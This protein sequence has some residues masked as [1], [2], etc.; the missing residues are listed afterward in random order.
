MLVNPTLVFAESGSRVRPPQLDLRGLLRIGLGL[1][2]MVLSHFARAER[3]LDP[4]LAP[5]VDVWQ[6]KSLH[7]YGVMIRAYVL[8]VGGLYAAHSGLASMQIGIMHWMGYT[9]PERYRLPFL[10]TGPDDFWRRWNRWVGAWA[11]RYLYFPLALALGRRWPR[12]SQPLK[13]AA[14]LS[15]FIAIG[16]L[17]DVATFAGRLNVRDAD[18][19]GVTSFLFLC[20]GAQLVLW[21]GFSHAPGLRKLPKVKSSRAST[22]LSWLLWSHLLMLTAALVVPYPRSGS[23]IIR[24]G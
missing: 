7:E 16:A 15:T 8:M 21:T 19:S 24:G 1:A 17:H 12:F 5:T 18:L 3:A 20:L 6:V 9:L 22:V 4:G 11:R 2:A 23:G 10:A 13:L 14:A